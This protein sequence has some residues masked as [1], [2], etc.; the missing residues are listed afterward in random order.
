MKN[1]I[2]LLML[3]SIITA[4][5]YQESYEVL[6]H[7]EEIDVIFDECVPFDYN[8]ETGDIGDGINE[9]WYSILPTNETNQTQHFYNTNSLST[10]TIKYY[11]N[12]LE[13]DN[14]SSSNLENLWDWSTA[15]SNPHND[16]NF[17][18]IE[19]IPV[20]TI[21]D[22]V[23]TGFINSM[24]KWNNIHIYSINS[25]STVTK[26]KLINIVEG[27]SE[28][29][30][31]IVSPM[32]TIKKG[33]QNNA[34]TLHIIEDGAN[35]YIFTKNHYNH[36]HMNKYSVVVN[37]LSMYVEGTDR[38]GAHEFGHVL[39]LADIDSVEN[40]NASDYHHE[41]LIMGYSKITPDPYDTPSQRQ[42][43]ITYKDIAGAMIT[44]GFHTAS[45]HKW[46]FSPTD[47]GGYKLICSICNGV[48]YAPSYPSGSIEYLSCDENHSISSGN[49]MPVA[50][51]ENKDY[52]KCKKCRYVASFENRQQQNYSYVN[53]NSTTHTVTNNIQG[54]YYTFVE[55]HNYTCSK[56]SSSRHEYRCVGCNYSYQGNHGNYSYSV[57]NKSEKHLKRCGGCNYI[58]EEPHA[59]SLEDYMDGN[60]TVTCSGCN[61]TFDKNSGQF[62]INNIN[63]LQ[64][65]ENGSY[66]LPNG[67]IILVEEDIQAYLD[68][69]LIFR[70]GNSEIM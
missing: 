43:N 40:S 35:D 48:K 34:T 47:Y 14:T 20:S 12:E 69:T 19:E 56:I 28:D 24:K 44:M 1:K 65:T 17:P 41:E 5:A 70:D 55:E 36:F 57:S 23:K 9:K 52:I 30:N 67:I 13:Y 53:N 4:F 15:F 6:A 68:G 10:Q 62:L 63:E 8:V 3:L 50:S 21:I 51:Y 11:V 32:N 54:L 46:M 25:D 49:M 58:I 45:D 42:T 64:R 29:W 38:T 7:F 33:R 22:E 60:N 26:R 66:I 27:T 39:G 16:V 37:A 59:V 18:D 61:R 31:I 2:I